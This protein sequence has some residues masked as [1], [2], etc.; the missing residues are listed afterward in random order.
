MLSKERVFWMIPCSKQVFPFGTLGSGVL[1]HQLWGNKSPDVNCLL[2][3]WH[4]HSHHGQL[5]Y[6][7]LTTS[8]LFNNRL[9]LAGPSWLQQT[10][11]GSPFK[12]RRPCRVVMPRVVP[13]PPYLQLL[14][15]WTGTE[16][17]SGGG[18]SFSPSELLVL[19]SSWLL[20]RNFARVG[21]RL[22]TNLFVPAQKP[23]KAVVNEGNSFF[24]SISVNL[25]MRTR[26]QPYPFT[27]VITINWSLVAHN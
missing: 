20:G 15:L 10:N 3:L 18:E 12:A 4:T 2:F 6:N 8:R 17:H 23:E 5:N 27:W 21:D 24:R 7:S 26:T 13:Q 1:G 16:S 14:V 19:P 22:S 25:L 11:T 9:L